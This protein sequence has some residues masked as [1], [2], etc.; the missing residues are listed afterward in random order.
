MR[1]ILFLSHAN[2]DD[3]EFTLWLAL[4]LVREGYKVWCDL[5]GLLGGETTWMDINKLIRERS[6]KFVCVVSRSSNERIGVLKELQLAENTARDNNLR[7][8]IIPA[9]IDDL[10]YREMNPFVVMLNAIAFENGWAKGLSNL[11]EKLER[12]EVPRSEDATPDAVSSWWREHYSAEQGVINEPEEYLSNWFPIEHMPEKIH[13][14]TL[15]RASIGKVEIPYDLPYP[16]FHEGEF[17]ISFAGA[18]D[19]E[20][21]IGELRIDKTAS[22]KL[23]EFLQ[24]TAEKKIVD[25]KEA[26]D[27]VFRLLRIA[28]E[29]MINERGLPIYDLSNAKCFYFKKGFADKDKAFFTGVNGERTFRNLVGYETKLSGK[30]YWHFGIQA[31]PLIYPYFAYIIKP[32][33]VFSDDGENIWDSHERMHSARRSQCKDWYN[34][35]WRD[36]SLAAVNWL[37]G[38]E[39]K[40]K[41]KL[42]SDLT[43]EIPNYPL[44]FKSPVSYIEPSKD[45]PRN[46]FEDDEDEMDEI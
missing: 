43:I 30:R 22:F 10:P 36:R 19:F 5:T 1:D 4:Q 18:P 42:G 15:R 27:F 3:N 14:H 46:E 24:G 20:G 2:P 11:L 28:W 29:Q 7:D 40:I 34:A 39:G 6:V 31:K 44:L 38:S 32:H 8:F 45:Q 17:L 26:R 21:L 16:A 41:P 9:H 13:F 25:R 35:E 33:V 37:A 23:D 12:D